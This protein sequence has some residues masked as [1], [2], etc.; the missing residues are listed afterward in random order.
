MDRI[1]VS[2]P[3]ITQ[4]EISYVTEAV[5]KA[6]YGNANTFHDRFERAF[7]AYL[8]KRFAIALPS[9]TSAIHL[10]L[11]ALG[12]KPGDEVIVPESTWIASVAPVIYVGATPVFA[13]VDPKSWCISVSSFEENVTPRTRA[14]IPVDLYGNVPD[15]DGLRSICRD[16]NIPIIEDAAQAIGTEYKQGKA[17]ALGDVGVFSFHGSKTL[18][19]GEGGLLAT[20]RQDVYDRVQV[21]R[22]HGRNPGDRMFFNAEVAYKYKMSS[23]QAALG[24][25]QLERIDELIAQKRRIFGWYRSRLADVE[26]IALN[27]EAP[28]IRNSYWMVTSIP[29]DDYDLPTAWLM[30]QLS[31]QGIDTRPFFHPLSSLPAF[32]H[33]N[34]EAHCR[35]RNPVSYALSRQGINLPSGMNLTEDLV[36][37]VCRTLKEI[38]VSRKRN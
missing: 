3:S 22:D 38:I 26:G 11:L 28:G 19:T 32:A 17:G 31:A 10:S 24:L 35:V 18:T 21:L 25:A 9:C 36:D 5:T 2:G 34:Q 33:L 4:K 29:S 7:A 15:F 8:G 30:Q 1:P 27:D 13:D 12:I 6:W 14:V 23:M 37:R 16:R 20:D